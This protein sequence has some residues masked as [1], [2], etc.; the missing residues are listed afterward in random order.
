MIA[1]KEF[2]VKYKYLFVF[3]IIFFVLPFNIHAASGC[4][5][6]V[7]APSSSPTDFKDV[8]C[9]VVDGINSLI[10]VVIG[11]T[12]LVFIWGLAKFILASGDEKKID[13]GKSL[14]FWG[15]IGL[16]VMVSVWGIVNIV[17]GSF[18]P[19]NIGIPLLKETP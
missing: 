4:I 13:D 6:S 7:A 14:M 3:L 8:V 17:Y 19:G 18:F 5:G 10:P 2:S 15:I 11:L 16:F 1:T 12:L 9:L